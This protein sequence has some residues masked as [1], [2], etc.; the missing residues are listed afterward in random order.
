[1][2]KLAPGSGDRGDRSVEDVI[3]AALRGEGLLVPQTDA[4]LRRFDE[5][6][7]KEVVEIP[8]HLLNP[9]W[10]FQSC[11]P[12]AE[13]D[14]D[15]KDSPIGSTQRA[16]AARDG[17]SISA[18]VAERMRDDLVARKTEQGQQAQQKPDSREM[19]T[20][21][22]SPSRLHEIADLAEWIAQERFPKGMAD[23]EALATAQNLGV[24]FNDYEDAFDGLLEHSSGSFVIYCN[25]RRV[26]GRNSD[27][28]R[29]T[30]AH[31]LGHFFI[32]EHRLK[33]ER[34]ESL[35]L[36]QCDYE[37][38]QPIEREADCFAAH[39]L[40]PASRFTK[41]SRGLVPG[42]SGILSLRRHFGTSVTS[43][44]CRYAE[45]GIAPCIVIKWSRDGVGW[46]FTSAAAREFGLGKTIESVAALPSESATAR[47][48]AGDAVPS[49]GFFESGTTAAYWFK[50]VENGSYRNDVL[51][52]QAIPLG[53][54]GTLTLLFPAKGSFTTI[55]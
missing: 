9:V 39:L 32:D 31:E 14:T 6:C 29:F 37:S 48:I 23:P 13:A 10:L 42:L 45:L 51:M 43:T 30:L 22:G 35:P 28:A 15:A 4:E 52:E 17:A 33:L 55:A 21:F 54:F 36:S 53:R 7:A 20:P 18:T 25:L 27:R 47:A 2:S 5:E 40:M 24:C 11:D 41:R 3:R 16:I 44:A 12:K 46:R 19:S 49:R 38:A 1:M 34:G 50:S 26:E 8:D